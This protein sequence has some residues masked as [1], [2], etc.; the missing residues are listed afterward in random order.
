MIHGCDDFTDQYFDAVADL[1]SVCIIKPCGLMRLQISS[2]L[3]ILSRH[4]NSYSTTRQSVH[5]RVFLIRSY[6]RAQPIITHTS[7]SPQEV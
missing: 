2:A 4:F 6:A 3:E 5:L 1:L 7:H